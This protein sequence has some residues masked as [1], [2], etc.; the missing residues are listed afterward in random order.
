MLLFIAFIL[1]C[2]AI[3]LIIKC[4]YINIKWYYEFYIILFKY[5]NMIL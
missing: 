2:N 3:M 1:L 5:Y 4:Y